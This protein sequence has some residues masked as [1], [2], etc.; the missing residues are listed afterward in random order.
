[1]KNI[2][3]ILILLAVVGLSAALVLTNHQI[4]ERAVELQAFKAVK[5]VPSPKPARRVATAPQQPPSPAD[6]S[7]VPVKPPPAGFGT[8]VMSALAGMMKNPY[9]KETIKAQQKMVVDLMY[10]S[11]PKYLNLTAEQKDQLHELVIERQQY[12][13][14]AGIAMMSGSPAER[15]KAT[16]QMMEAKTGYDQVIQ[17]MLGPQNNEV[18]K[19]YEASMPEHSTVGMFKSSLTGADVLSDQQEF[20]LITALYQERKNMPTDSLPNKGDQSSDPS[21]QT[22]EQIT[23]TLGQ[24]EQ[25]QQ[26]NLLR[27]EAILNPSQL[28]QFKQ[29]QKQMADMQAMGLKMAAQMFGQP[30][31]GGAAPTP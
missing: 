10:G 3:L 19:Q 15:K 13:A 6:T 17:D 14:E 21:Q 16:D 5:H 23:K 24:L 30:K 7:P 1:M 28:E 29:Y 2:W 8:N 25:L 22:E 26:R 31:A 27:A 4:N 12:M 20:D 18:F 11:L 9:M